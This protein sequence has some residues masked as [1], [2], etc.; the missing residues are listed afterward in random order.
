MEFMSAEH[1]AAMNALLQ[2]H[3]DVRKECAE[4]PRT[5]ALGYRL[6]GGPSGTVHWTLRFDDTVIFALGEHPS[7]DLTIV[8]DW[9]RMIRSAAAARARQQV[10]PGVVLEGDTSVMTVIESAWVR[11]RAV[12]TLDVEFPEV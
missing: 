12:A 10:D 4:L 11:A 3:E 5:Y 9:R 8:G 6:S 2:D 7:P 1:V